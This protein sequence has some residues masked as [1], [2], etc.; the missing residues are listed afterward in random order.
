MLKKILFVILIFTL[1]AGF[2]SFFIKN[3]NIPQPAPQA[4]VLEIY[5]KIKENYWDNLSD[6]QLLELFRLSLQTDKIQTREDLTKAV[7]KITKDQAVTVSSAVLASLNPPGRSGLFTTAQEVALKNTVENIN[8][9]KDLY[10]DLGLNKGASQEAVE[11]AFAQK[12][13]ELQ[14]DEEKLKQIAYAKDVLSK[15]EQKQRYDE[16]GVEPAI[17]A[18]PVNY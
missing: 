11:Q 15:T 5:D 10:K 17:F 3:K 2:G 14:G 1:G 8:P 18:K 7:E 4:F 9:E 12:S 13:K 16:K 6:A